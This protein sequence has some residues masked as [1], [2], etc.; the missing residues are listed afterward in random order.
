MSVRNLALRYG[1]V[2]A[3]RDMNL[4]VGQGTIH[5]VTGESGAGKATL[6]KVLVG[7]VKPDSGIIRIGDQAVAIDNPVIAKKHGV[8]VVHQ[9]SACLPTTRCWPICS[10]TANR[11][12]TA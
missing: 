1:G 9:G 11:C 7:V 5:A 2:V 10:S 4:S 3:L 12:A 8:G 6:V